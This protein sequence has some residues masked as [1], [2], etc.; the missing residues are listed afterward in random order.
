MS[1]DSYVALTRRH[2]RLFQDPED[3]RGLRILTDG[4]RVRTEQARIRAELRLRG[5][6]DA[7]SELGVL[8]DD[9]WFLVLRD[10][11]EI[12][13][14]DPV[15]YIRMINRKTL[16]GTPGV[17]IFPC[18]AGRVLLLRHLRHATRASAWEIPRGFGK[19]G[20]V[21]EDNA[22]RELK[23]ETGG[24]EA[25]R[26]VPLGKAIPDSGAIFDSVHF[27]YAE[28]HDCNSPGKRPTAAARREGIVEYMSATMA[29][30]DHMIVTDQLTDAFTMT[31]YAK[32]RAHGLITSP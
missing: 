11:V 30:L 16:E 1:W 19:R 3:D 13:D 18:C 12:P 32:A 4:E 8:V 2:P 6:P 7:W 14:E 17:A 20:L 28:L 22:R 31:A 26:M 29:E 27:Y 21:V 24:L 23:K 9:P 15:G 10:L 5:K 25:M